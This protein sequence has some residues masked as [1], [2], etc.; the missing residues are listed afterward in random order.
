MTSGVD[1][2]RSPWRGSRRAP[3]PGAWRHGVW[4]DGYPDLYGCQCGQAGNGSIV[5]DPKGDE[6]M[7]EQLHRSRSEAGR[8]FLEW[9]PEGGLSYNP[10][11]RG[12]ET[13]I[14]DK[15]LAG[16]RFTEPHYLRQAQRYLGHVCVLC[17]PPRG[18]QPA[19][20]RRATRP[21][22]IGALSHVTWAE[23]ESDRTFAH[24]DSLTAR[25]RADLAGVRDRLAILV[26]SD[27]GAVAGPAERG[28]GHWIYQFST[29]SRLSYFRPR[30]DTR[31]AACQMLGAAIV[32]DL[33]TTV[34][35]LQGQP[36]RHDG[37][38]R[39]VLSAGSR[40]AGGDVVGRAA[41]GLSLLLRTRRLSDL[42]LPGGS[43]AE[44]SW[45][46]YPS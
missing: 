18:A 20:D 40:R 4:Q 28:A 38:D 33:Q 29:R 10:F 44:Q 34:A 27:V 12:G 30:S 6:A 23:T 13:E 5:L 25:Q 36:Y 42:R 15:A 3:H 9:T 7:R 35:A 39:R 19:R 8:E 32:R 2:S 45:A 46:T 41:G 31:A 14:A 11:A 21:A 37:G 1:Q 17:A 24:L 16:E 26:E 22:A 43:A